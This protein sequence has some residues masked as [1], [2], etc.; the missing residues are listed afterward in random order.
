MAFSTVY[1]S[2]SFEERAILW[3]NLS[4]LAELQSMAWVIAGY[5]NEPLLDDDKYRGRVVSINRS[6]Q[7]K[8]CLDKCSMMDLGLTGSRFTW[9]NGRELSAL[10]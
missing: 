3:N 9:I 4:N 2:P 1:V 6:L 7:F 10:I 8:E 5:F